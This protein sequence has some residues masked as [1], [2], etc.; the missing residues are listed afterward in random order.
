M[1]TELDNLF[2]RLGKGV[3]E[4]L[5]PISAIKGMEATGDR[6]V[7]IYLKPEYSFKDSGYVIVAGGDLEEI[8][9]IINKTITGAFKEIAMD[10]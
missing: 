10:E 3:C 9:E 8:Q 1:K 6:H 5:L 7:K 4:V 2:V